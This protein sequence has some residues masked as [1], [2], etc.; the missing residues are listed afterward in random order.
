[1]Q[2]SFFFSFLVLGVLQSREE[3]HKV[4]K[5]SLQKAKSSRD[6]FAGEDY[7]HPQTQQ[8]QKKETSE[9]SFSSFFCSQNDPTFSLVEESSLFECECLRKYTDELNSFFFFSQ[10]SPFLCLV[11]NLC[12][13]SARF[14]DSQQQSTPFFIGSYSMLI[15]FFLFSFFFF[16]VFQL[17]SVFLNYKVTSFSFRLQF[18]LQWFAIEKEYVVFL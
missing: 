16:T 15:A 12:V 3:T 5:K 1:M 13:P 17:L 10:L 14:A 11:Q 2:C 9:S 8:Q 18:L 7:I 4:H 6:A